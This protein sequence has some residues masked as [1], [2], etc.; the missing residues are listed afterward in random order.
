M[1]TFAWWL[2]AQNERV[3]FGITEAAAYRSLKSPLSLFE[4]HYYSTVF[5]FPFAWHLALLSMLFQNKTLERQPSHT[6]THTQE[7]K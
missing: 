3:I 7:R 1:F 5:F 4:S 2:Q 6:Q